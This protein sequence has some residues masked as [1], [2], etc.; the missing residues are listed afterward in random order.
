MD[1]TEPAGKRVDERDIRILMALQDDARIS[2]KDLAK[3]VN[4]T[5]TPCLRRVA[6]LEK[7][8]YIKR[9]KAVIDYHKLGY[10]IRAFVFATRKRDYNKDEVWSKVAEIPEVISCYIISGE[11]DMIAEVIAKDMQDYSAILMK[12]INGIDGIYD[13]RSMFAMETLKTEAS[14]SLAI[15]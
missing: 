14:F 13:A 15:K 5:Q 1:A 4:L 3:Q 7:E 8:G 11:H 2:N 12:K 9:Y 6:L 10:S